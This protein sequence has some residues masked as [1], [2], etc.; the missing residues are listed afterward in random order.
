MTLLSHVQ[1]KKTIDPGWALIAT[2][3]VNI[4]DKITDP[5]ELAIRKICSARFLIAVGTTWFMYKLSLVILTKN[6][7][8]AQVIF[9]CFSTA[10][11]TIIGFYF[12]ASMNTPI[13]G[14]PKEDNKTM[15]QVIAAF[16]LVALLA[17]PAFARENDNEDQAG[18]G[19]EIVVFEAP[20]AKL[21]PE[22]I[23]DYEKDIK[24]DS[25]NFMAK[26]KLNVFNWLEE[27]AK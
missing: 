3:I 24:N 25:F 14:K 18:V 2:S 8:A 11:G 9:T 26:V 5:L 16:A 12:G 19:A 17:T 22:V 7:E 21:Q 27:T 1:E 10:W 20:N 4:I 6:P 15:K 13:E 23:L